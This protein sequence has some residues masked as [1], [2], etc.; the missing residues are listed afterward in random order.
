MWHNPFL[1][2][3]PMFEGWKETYEQFVSTASQ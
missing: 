1:G 3:D 2:T